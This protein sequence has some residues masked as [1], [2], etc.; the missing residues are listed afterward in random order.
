MASDPRFPIGLWIRVEH[1]KCYDE[2]DGWGNAEPYLWTVFFKVDGDT[3]S[4]ND[5]GKLIGSATVVSTPGSHGNLGTS[6]VDAGDDVLVPDAI[7]SWQTVL[8]PIP[9]ANSL[10]P[11]VGNDLPGFAGVVCILMEEDNVSDSG[12]E[13]GHQALNDAV[14]EAVD[15]IIATRDAAHK[16]PSK[17]EIEQFKG[18]IKSKLTNAIENSLSFFGGIWAWLNED[19]EIGD[20]VLFHDHDEL[21]TQHVI[22][23][24]EH[25]KNGNGDWELFGS[26][27]AIPVC[28]ADAVATIVE[29]LSDSSQGNTYSHISKVMREFRE[30]EFIRWPG[31]NEWWELATR[32][33]PQLALALL[34]DKQL[35]NSAATLLES[36][37]MANNRRTRIDASRALALLP[38]LRGR[39]VNQT[40][41]VLSSVAPARYPKPR[42]V[43]KLLH[44]KP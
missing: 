37:A 30:Q 25:W 13:A 9:V 16:E 3:V 24:S 28:P 41:E 7:G 14:Q 40:I 44:S 33:T 36:L 15:E 34:R 39:T 43:L 8:K 29:P 22:D 23:F 42:G 26:F 4:L 10:K 1:I 20:E 6:D 27:I 38:H 35:R 18:V 21:A 19:D 11:L 12:A 17:E 2:A 32:N 31:L 5:A